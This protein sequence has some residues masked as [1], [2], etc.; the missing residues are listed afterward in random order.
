MNNPEETARES[1]AFKMDVE[2]MQK[3]LAEFLHAAGLSEAAEG[4]APRKA[5]EAWASELLS[6]YGRDPIKVLGETWRND[7]S[8]LVTVTGIPFVSVCAHHLLPFYGF[9]HVAYLPGGKLVGLSRLALLVDCLACRLQIQEQLGEQVCE[10]LM[11]GAD[12]RG[13]ACYLLASHDCLGAR[14]VEYSGTQVQSF[15]YRGAFV[16]DPTLRNEFLQL[17]QARE[18]FKDE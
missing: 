2:A 8:G 6:G 11:E 13:A 1:A 18:S 14:K 7:S 16:D 9:A 12:A 15:A 4:Q 5:A 10:T 3:A 17:V